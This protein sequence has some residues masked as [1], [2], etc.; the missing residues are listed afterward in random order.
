MSRAVRFQVS[1]NASVRSQEFAK[2]IK[3]K[4]DEGVGRGPSGP[5]HAQ[6]TGSVV[7]LAGM[8]FCITTKFRF[9]DRAPGGTV[10]LI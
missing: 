6:F 1:A 7:A 4:A 2:L 5:L 3:T 9:P 8:P 10:K